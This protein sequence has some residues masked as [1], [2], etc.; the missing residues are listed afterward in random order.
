M[1]EQRIQ[2]S[3]SERESSTSSWAAETRLP[4]L[5]AKAVAGEVAATDQ[6]FVGAGFAELRGHRSAGRAV[7]TN[8]AESMCASHCLAC[9]KYVSPICE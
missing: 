2:K 3:S 8:D 9:E 5:V 4:S 7:T 6:D 1:V